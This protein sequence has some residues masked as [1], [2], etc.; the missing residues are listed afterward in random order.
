[1]NT[2]EAPKNSQRIQVQVAVDT[3]EL[4]TWAGKHADAGNHGVAH[5]LYRAA[6]RYD[7]QIIDLKQLRKR[8]TRATA[9]LI[10]LRNTA[11]EWEALPCV[12]GYRIANVD[13]DDSQCLHCASKEVLNVLDA[14]GG[15]L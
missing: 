13:S 2:P 12:S 6:E 7:D 10:P 9:L 1:M 14:L 11:E 5:A 3:D 15:V 4:R 8:L